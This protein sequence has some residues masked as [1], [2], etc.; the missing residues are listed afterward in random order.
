M[1]GEGELRQEDEPFSLQQ[2]FNLNIE[3][4]VLPPVSVVIKGFTPKRGLDS[5]CR[6]GTIVIHKFLP[7]AILFIK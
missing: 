1:S 6:T 4:D 7:P 2:Y 3:P 5:T